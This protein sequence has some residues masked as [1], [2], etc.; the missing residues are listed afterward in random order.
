MSG[1][2]QMTSEAKYMKIMSLIA[3]FAGLAIAIIGIVLCILDFD[4]ADVLVI[5]SGVLGCGVGASGARK[6]NVPSSA[7]GIVVPAIII[8]L[9]CIVAA[10]VA[11]YLNA[12]IPDIIADALAGISCANVSLSAQRIVKAL[13]KV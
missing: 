1:G 6:A 4:I 3:L 8:G 5:I 7:K 10:G 2:N 13:E 12:D 11:T 9:A